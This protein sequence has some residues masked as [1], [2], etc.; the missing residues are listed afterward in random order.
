MVFPTQVAIVGVVLTLPV[1]IMLHEAAH[2]F[3]A[4]RA[5]MKVTEF[6]VGFGPRLWSVKRGET[7]YGVKAVV[8]GG[9]CRII[10]MTNLEEVAPEDEPR[11]YRN[12][13]WGPKVLVAAAGPATH[14]FLAAVLMF[15]VIYFAGDLRNE[16]VTTTL[17]Q[18]SQGA[19]KAGLQP[20]DTII[21]VN[22]TTVNNWDQ[23]PTLVAGTA[24]NPTAAGDTIRVV[25]RRG[26]AV[27]EKNV[28]V[29]LATDQNGEVLK[30]A[31]G[32]TRL[33]AGV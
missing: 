18:V 8:L 21:A 9:Y 31:N 6:F 27:L 1:I 20:G 32:Q 11:A 29:G 16:R 26:D 2:F 10:G 19:E 3:A 7:E 25:V 28:V 30:D 14:F 33:V 4:K 13:P 17:D 24:D 15:G 23:V 5:G 22:G 12:K